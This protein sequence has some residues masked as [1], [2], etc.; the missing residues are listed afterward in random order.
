MSVPRVYT[1]IAAITADLSRKGIAKRQTNQRDQYQYR[2]IDDVL[3]ELSPLLAQHR[4]CILP[5][6]QKR[7]VTERRDRHGDLLI[8][9]TLKAAFDLVCAEDG[10][11]HVIES[12]GE[13][14]DAGDKATSKAMTAAYKYAVI[15]AFC[16]PVEG[17]DDADSQ[18]HRLRVADNVV[19]PVQ[20]WARWAEDVI[21][22]VGSCQT[23]E[24]VDRVQESN[25]GLLRAVA[26][27][28][29][30]LFASIGEAIRARRAEV[31]PPPA[32]AKSVKSNGK[33]KPAGRRRVAAGAHA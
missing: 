14:L 26:M 24:A 23:A 27:H 8:N 5:R 4:L 1:A 28:E 15:Q 30:K 20:G 18:S 32:E 3:N 7:S 25:R 9:V 16:I 19:E 33:A 22:I 10:S 11:H 12:F 13:A 29:P 31:A 2:G 21:E 6:I 17:G